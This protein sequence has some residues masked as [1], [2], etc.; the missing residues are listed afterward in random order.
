LT[1]LHL[2]VRYRRTKTIALEAKEDIKGTQEII[3]ATSKPI[4]QEGKKV[5]KEMCGFL[6]ASEP[7]KLHQDEI[8]NLNRPV[9]HKETEAVLS[10]SLLEVVPGLD[11]S[12]AEFYQTSK[13]NL[14][15]MLHRLVHNRYKKHPQTSFMKLVLL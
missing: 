14:Q 7:K 11:G 10:G 4:A 1:N 12:M 6:A 8:S 3:K 15:P 13:E 2:K 9:T 5:L